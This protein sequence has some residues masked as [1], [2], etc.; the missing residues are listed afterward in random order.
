MVLLGASVCG[1]AAGESVKSPDGRLELR[2]LARDGVV[3]YALA[4][5]GREVV[6]PTPVS[7]SLEG[8]ADLAVE[9][10][11]DVRRGKLDETIP[12]VVPTFAAEIEVKANTLAFSVGGGLSL[13]ARAHD[14]LVAFRWLTDR[15]GPLVV[16][17]ERFGFR[18][19]EDY[20]MFY[21]VPNGKDYISHQENT[22]PHLRVS[23]TKGLE[24]G[25]VP[26]LLELG[27]GGYL[28]ATDVNVS[29]YPGLYVSGTGRPELEARFPAV[30]E[31]LVYH[32][33]GDQKIPRRAD[34]IARTAGPRAFPWRAMMITTAR[35]LLTP[36]SLYSLA[37]APKIA[38]TSWIRPGKVV[39]DW[40]HDWNIRDVGFKPGRNTETYR[41][42]I[43]HA[44]ANGIPYI[45][46]DEG[47]SRKDGKGEGLLEVVP[48]IDMPALA[49]YGREKGVGLILWM[50]S[51]SL[52][53]EFDAAFPQFAEWGIKGLKVDF[54]VRDDQPM[55]DFCE[56]VAEAAARHKL[57]V[58]YHGGSKPTGLQR[59]WP[60]VLEHESVLG[61][62]QS[63]WSDKACPDYAVLLPFIRM[64]VGPMDYTPGAML[65]MQRDVFR[66]DN[67]LPASL[68]TRC[69]QLALYVVFLAPLQM[70]ADS[71]THYRENPDAMAFL[72]RVPTTWDETRV[73]S[74]TVGG[75]LAVARRKGDEWWIGAL[76]DWTPREITVKT[77]FL[78][79][80]DYLMESWEDGPD[81]AKK[82][83]DHLLRSARV[84]KDSGIT[85]RM[86]PGGGFAAVLRKMAA[87]PQVRLAP[88]SHWLAEDG[89]RWTA[90]YG[91][92]SDDS[93][94]FVKVTAPDG[95][96]LTLPQLP[97]A[98]GARYSDE[99]RMVWWEH[100]GEVSVDIR[101]KDG[102]WEPNR[103]HLKPDGPGR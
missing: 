62:E 64:A 97:S 2:F 44:A 23:E 30:P 77:D 37:D 32:N 34:F 87:T 1:H 73:L 13:E 38:D 72:R 92:L 85:I 15:E 96:E 82:G 68:G 93:L 31:E 39:W 58:D 51:Y 75:E 16:R 94:F 47:W 35:G 25:P 26:F 90:R 60:N 101:N 46:L 91:S 41:H 4:V 18:F 103:F 59:T 29:G 56:R 99:H 21:P 9:G 100:Q 10:F 71:P 8:A 11:T 78:G 98:S 27:G 76:T 70:L 42:Y 50:T 74:A 67:R 63:K 89:S 88:P 48:E 81:A 40:W 86:A 22:F 57:L 69:Q 24:T 95:R 66:A 6:E 65:N 54:M 79:T 43:D 80:G 45:I 49:A 53:R 55:M 33:K 5:D 17:G 19:A 12:M 3:H 102:E 28:L 84:D 83:A 7:L 14:D 20:R 61:L 36:G 52:E